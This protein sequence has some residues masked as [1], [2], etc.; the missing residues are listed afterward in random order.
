MVVAENAWHQ[1][2]ALPLPKGAQA[3]SSFRGVGRLAPG[4]LGRY[5]VSATV[6][7][8]WQDHLKVSGK[9]WNDPAARWVRESF[10]DDDYLPPPEP[11]FPNWQV[12]GTLDHDE[13]TGPE[14]WLLALLQARPEQWESRQKIPRNGRVA[15]IRLSDGG[16]RNFATTW[17]RDDLPELQ[18]P[19]PG[20]R[21]PASGPLPQ[22]PVP[23]VEG[24]F[25]TWAQEFEYEGFE[26]A[27]DYFDGSVLDDDWSDMEGDDEDDQYS[28]LA[29]RYVDFD[30]DDRPLWER[31]LDPDGDRA[32]DEFDASPIESPDWDHDDWG[33]WAEDDLDGDGEDGEDYETT[34][35]ELQCQNPHG[36]NGTVKAKSRCGPCLEYRRTHR[37]PERP[38][39]LINRARRR[40]LVV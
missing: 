13:G 28:A 26:S 4:G 27:Y 14:A 7:T 25:S 9:P 11:P 35:P 40:V 2:L 23:A 8:R 36:C 31:E 39:R 33:D 20:L 3:R 34:V 38:L 32:L 18:A 16:W 17:T 29:S 24:E 19:L 22:R 5:G 1:A 21:P 10:P 6:A 30:I 37:G 15:R 12:R